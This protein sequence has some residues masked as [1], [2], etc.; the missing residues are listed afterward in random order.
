MRDRHPV[1]IDASRNCSRVQAE[2][3]GNC[4]GKL[5]SCSYQSGS[6]YSDKSLIFASCGN[7]AVGDGEQ[8]DCGSF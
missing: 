4:G 3:T 1:L 6:E 8:C 7:T 2:V 5:C